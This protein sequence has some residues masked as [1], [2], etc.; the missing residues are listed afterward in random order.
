MDYAIWHLDGPEQLKF[1]DDILPHVT[2]IQWVPGVKPGVPQDGAEDWMPLYK[3]I[4][5]A[6]KNIQM[7]ILDHALIPHVYKKLDPK[8]LFVY[9]VYMSRAQA[10]CYLP[11]FMGGDGGKLVS[12]VLGWLKK[13]NKNKLSKVE[14]GNF[15]AENNITIEKVLESQVLRE[16]KKSLKG[17]KL[18]YISE[19]S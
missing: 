2:G 18:R 4:Q 15:L 13:N 3:K 6:G 5:K 17:Y 19:K 7:M 16:A 14:L 11:E 1:V 10:N 9:T 8:G 12:S